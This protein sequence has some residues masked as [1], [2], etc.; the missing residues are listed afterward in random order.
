MAPSSNGQ[1][2]SLSP[3]E[4]EFDSPRGYYNATHFI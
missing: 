4:W 3:R 1:D 2:A